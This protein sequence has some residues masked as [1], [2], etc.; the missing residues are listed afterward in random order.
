MRRESCPSRKTATS[1]SRH[2][3]DR[4]QVVRRAS[5]AGRTSRQGPPA[6]SDGSGGIVHSDGGRFSLSGGG[7][8][9]GRRGEGRER[10]RDRDGCSSST[11]T[12]HAPAMN[13]QPR[14]MA[15]VSLVRIMPASAMPVAHR[16]RRAPSC[17]SPH[18]PQHPSTRKNTSHASWIAS[19]WKYRFRRRHRHRHR[20]PRARPPVEEPVEAKQPVHR[21]DADQRRRQAQRPQVAPEQ[22]LEH[23]NST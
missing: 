10:A 2:R 21:Q 20:S 1:T 19:R 6:S 5:V 14:W 11:N 22:A 17:Q 12:R 23:T 16:C 13:R 8:G 4:P 18:T 9:A 7:A 15:Y 3:H